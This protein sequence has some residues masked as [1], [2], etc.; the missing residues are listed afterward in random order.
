M[1]PNWITSGSA[2]LEAEAKC[3]PV[4]QNQDIRTNVA[5]AATVAPEVSNSSGSRKMLRCVHFLAESS[6]MELGAARSNA[7]A[8]G[9]KS[10]NDQILAKAWLINATNNHQRTTG[11]DHAATSA[12]ITESS[13]TV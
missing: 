3:Y 8:L 11:A 10:M 9:M 7:M 13:N 4:N 5:N 1:Y 2:K 12:E 6:V